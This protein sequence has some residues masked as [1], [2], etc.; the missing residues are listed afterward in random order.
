MSSPTPVD[1]ESQESPPQ[2]NK[3]YTSHILRS[4]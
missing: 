4:R 3:V 1:N 2:L